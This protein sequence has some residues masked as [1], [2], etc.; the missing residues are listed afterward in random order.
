MTS[1]A[2]G[3]NPIGQLTHDHDHLSDLVHAAASLLSRVERAECTF[4]DVV[5]E[6][7]DGVESLREALLAHF[8][9]EEEGLFPFVERH[10]PALGAQVAALLADHDAVVAGA[11]ALGRELR[12][13]HGQAACA[14]GFARF[15]EIYAAHAQAELSLLRDVDAKL[16][17]ANREELRA[18]LAAI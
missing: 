14:V 12:T 1:K 16:D 4:A 7:E 17:A 5:D 9:I 18:L 15:V 6:L 3:D 11:A 10:V 13:D 8:A 2:G